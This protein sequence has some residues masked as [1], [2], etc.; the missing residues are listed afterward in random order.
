M[1]TILVCLHIIY[2]ERPYFQMGE[3]VILVL[4]EVVEEV[5][6][7]LILIGIQNGILGQ[8]FMMDIG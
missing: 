6:V 4:E 7:G 2:R 8:R 1:D 3:K 5:S